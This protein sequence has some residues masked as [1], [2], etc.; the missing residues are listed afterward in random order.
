MFFSPKKDA[1]IKTKQEYVEKFNEEFKR[2]LDSGRERLVFSTQTLSEDDANFY[3]KQVPQC[4]RTFEESQHSYYE[5]EVLESFEKNLISQ[6]AEY[7]IVAFVK[8]KALGQAPYLEPGLEMISRVHSHASL[9]EL[10][11][12]SNWNYYSSIKHFFNMENIGSFVDSLIELGEKPS[13]L[14]KDIIVAE[15]SYD[16]L[17]RKLLKES[18]PLQEALI[19]LD[20]RNASADEYLFQ[21]MRKNISNS[22]KYKPL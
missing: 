22:N 5:N 14:F 15:E 10:K 1:V 11:P 4:W 17:T 12:Q 21:E 16:S 7:Q 19:E 18:S 6:N 2:F 9:P 3:R 20:K 13:E 8:P